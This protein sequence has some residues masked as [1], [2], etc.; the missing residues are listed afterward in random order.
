MKANAS[1]RE[2]CNLR[3]IVEKAEC[4]LAPHHIVQVLDHFGH[5][6]PNG[7][8]QCIAMELVGPTLKTFFTMR[9]GTGGALLD[10]PTLYELS[11]Q[12][13]KAISWLHSVEVCHGGKRDSS[14]NLI[15]DGQVLCGVTQDYLL[16]SRYYLFRYCLRLPPFMACNGHSML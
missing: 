7:L 2:S 11:I 10:I 8:H 15:R 12:L 4:N 13:L 1:F 9:R 3:H 5:Q 16:V 14:V 6:G